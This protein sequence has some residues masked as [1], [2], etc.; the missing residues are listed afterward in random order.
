MSTAVILVPTL[1]TDDSQ[2]E[3]EHINPKAKE[4]LDKLLENG[5]EIEIMNNFEYKGILYTHYVLKRR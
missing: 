1:W 3:A 2:I 5:W 4:K